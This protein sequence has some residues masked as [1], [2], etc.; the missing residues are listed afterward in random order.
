[1]PSCASDTEP[2]LKCLVS[3]FALQ[4]ARKLQ[5]MDDE[6]ED[7]LDFKGGR[8]SKRRRRKLRRP[9][10]MYKTIKEGIELSIHPSSFLFQKEPK[11]EWVCFN[12]LI[13]TSKKYLRGVSEVKEQW[14]VELA[15][16]LY[17]SEIVEKSKKLLV[18]KP[19]AKKRAKLNQA[20]MCD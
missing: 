4:V 14:L 5:P 8:N 3:S 6:D 7:N 20:L 19:N 18:M 16:K 17:S 9:K 10:A 1:L 12:E 15:P 11:P 13:L 2:I